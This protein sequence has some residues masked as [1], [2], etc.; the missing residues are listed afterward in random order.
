MRICIIY[1]VAVS[2]V[3]LVDYKTRAFNVFQNSKAQLSLLYFIKSM[4]KFPQRIKWSVA[5]TICNQVI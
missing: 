4:L 5:V 3:M 2:P 1:E